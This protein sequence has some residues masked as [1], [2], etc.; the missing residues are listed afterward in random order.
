[1]TF[2]VRSI[3]EAILNPEFKSKHLVVPGPRKCND[4]ILLK[5]NQWAK[6]P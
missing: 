4:N 2:S 3:L 6:I 1:M 5:L